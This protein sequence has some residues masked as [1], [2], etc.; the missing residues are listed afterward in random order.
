MISAWPGFNVSF[1]MTSMA[2]LL[3]FDDECGTVEIPDLL[4]HACGF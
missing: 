1:K 2:L 4:R 3:G